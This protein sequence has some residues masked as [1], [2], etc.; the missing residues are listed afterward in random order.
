MEIES[1]DKNGYCLIRIKEDIS[2]ETDVAQFKTS[3]QPYLDQGHINIA[4]SFTKNSIFYSTIIAILVQILGRVKEFDGNFAL[5]HPNTSMLEMIRLVG[6][7][8]LI[9]MHTSEENIGS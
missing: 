5:V 1:L 8:K 3:I 2:H 7:G 9:E 4:L 6:L